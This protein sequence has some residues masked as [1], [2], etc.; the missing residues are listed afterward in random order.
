VVVAADAGESGEEGGL[1][2]K[3]HASAQTALREIGLLSPLK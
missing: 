2:R 1:V 3:E